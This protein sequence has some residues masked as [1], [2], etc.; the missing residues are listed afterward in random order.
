[1]AETLAEDAADAPLD[2]AAIRSRLERLAL[3]RRGEEEVASAAAAAADAVRRLPSVE[4]VEPLQG[5]EF[6]A[7]A[8]SAA[9]MESDFDAFM[10]WLSKE[11]SLAE[12][13][14]RKLSVEISSVAETT[15]KDSIQLD[16]DI[17]ELESSLKKID[18]QGLKHLEASH[19]AEL[20]VSTDSCR[21]QIKFDKDYKYE[22][23][24]LN[25]QLE[26]YENDLKLLENQ[27]SAEAM[28]ELES[29]LSE[30]NVL[31]FK[32]NCL[33]VFLKEAVLTPECLMYGKESDCSVNSFVSDHELLI[34]V[35]ENMEPKKVQI[36]PDDTCVDILLDKLKASRETI[37]TTS[38]G[39][40]IRQ[41]Q[42]HIIINTLRRS[43]VKDAN[44]SR[45]SFEYIDK[46]GTILAHL[47]GG[48]DA[49]IKISADWPLSSCGLK[50]IS[51]HSSRAQ[52][53]D[54]SLA[55]LS[56][57]KE[58]ANGLELQTRRHLV[59]FVD[60]IEDIL[61]REMRS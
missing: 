34:E 54:I 43:L 55:L 38:L 41:F 50:L 23:L 35:G 40:I 47:A 58:L 49:F 21:D 14:N 18:S 51:I 61:F 3:S 37:S 6:D 22:V 1:M 48:I 60:A 53:A 32:D 33:R 9:P 29:M 56:K 25:Q 15:L 20:S 7:W 16:A 57:T 26:K 28:W 46:D 13:E 11:V 24:E 19:I 17:A 4:D 2:A 27:K 44:N 8:S 30:A 10:E 5:L 12:E 59:K 42:H 31:D 36:F 45:H 52:S 39:W